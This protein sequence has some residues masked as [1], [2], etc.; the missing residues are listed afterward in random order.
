[1]SNG[2]QAV[3]PFPLKAIAKM[4]PSELPTKNELQNAIPKH[5]FTYSI[6]MSLWLV[7][8]DTIVNGLIFYVGWNYLP[9]DC[10]SCSNPL[11]W[12][13]VKAAWHVYYF[14]QGTAFTGWWVLAHE[15]GH[16]GFSDNT[17]LCDTV[18]W[19]LHSFL[20]VPYFSWQ[21]SHSQHHA[22][23]N[24]LQDG[25]SHVPYSTEFGE[26]YRKMFDA[27]GEDAFAVYQL[28]GHW[29]LGWPVYLIFNTTGARRN[30][31]R[32]EITTIRD[33]FRPSSSLFPASRSWDARIYLSTLGVCLA[34]LGLFFAGQQWGHYK[35]ACFYWPSYLWCNFWLITYTWLQ[36]TSVDMPHFG[37]DE[38]TFVRGA[39]CTTDR[40]YGIF[41]WMHHHIGSTH[42]AHHLFSRIPCYRAVEATAALKAYLE[43]K[44]LYHYDGTNFVAAAWKIAHECHYV[45]GTDGIQH[46]KS[47]RD[48]KK[49]GKK[50][51]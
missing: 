36:H 31:N 11:S 6:P 21:Y 46:Y 29:L 45:E 35:V 34:L 33:H 22:K 8:R 47:L 1:M 42:V 38:W 50:T 30:G 13:C 9:M 19:I 18:G 4:K 25:E 28:I 37:D 20:L 15:C 2:Q 44:G 17:K 43:P 27:I 5:C 41:D 3:V 16:R 24:H 7:L 26:C 51:Q 40:P 23:T 48:T 10:S 14:L 39:L 12:L 49:E 32:T